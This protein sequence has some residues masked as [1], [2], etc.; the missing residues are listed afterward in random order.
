MNH[1]E[2]LGGCPVIPLYSALRRMGLD[3]DDPPG[4]RI[5]CVEAG[6]AYADDL[7][8]GIAVVSDGS[9]DGVVSHANLDEL[10][11]PL[12]VRWAQDSGDLLRIYQRELGRIGLARSV[13]VAMLMHDMQ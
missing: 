5:R 13:N 2:H 1:L 3:Y 11:S 4:P 12:K 9:R 7:T 10:K 8:T 6:P